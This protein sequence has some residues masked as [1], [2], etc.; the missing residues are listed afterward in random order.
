VIVDTRKIY[1]TEAF[2]AD[3]GD[4]ADTPHPA[5]ENTLRGFVERRR[6]YLLGTER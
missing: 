5:P 4:S 2:Y 3:V 6:A 1:S